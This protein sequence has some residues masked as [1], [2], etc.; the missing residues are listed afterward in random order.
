MT[1]R[2]ISRKFAF[3]AILLCANPV[4]AASDDENRQGKKID[5]GGIALNTN[6]MEV[7]IISGEWKDG[8]VLYFQAWDR[9]E[10]LIVRKETHKSVEGAPSLGVD[11]RWSVSDI[12]PQAEILSVANKYS[13][14]LI[15]PD[16]EGITRE[17][18][19]SD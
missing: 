3:G 15:F 12:P 13:T 6:N 14:V 8:S 5:A 10:A 4:F 16:A 7:C 2:E 18:L 1:I 11:D 19:I 9:C 17:I